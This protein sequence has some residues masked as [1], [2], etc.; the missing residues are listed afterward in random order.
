[1]DLAQA[2]EV[3]LR[4]TFPTNRQS[5][6]GIIAPVLLSFFIGSFV[7]ALMRKSLLALIG[8]AADQTILH[9]REHP[10]ALILP[11]MT[12]S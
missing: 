1:M 2:I 4:L 10:S 5:T 8:L 11:M 3:R 7:I 9:D 6:S 12:T